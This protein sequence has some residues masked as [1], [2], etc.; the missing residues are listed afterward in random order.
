MLAFMCAGVGAK[1][2][3]GY[4]ARVSDHTGFELVVARDGRYFPDPGGFA[5]VAWSL[6]AAGLL[7]LKLEVRRAPPSA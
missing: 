3:H 7:A 5:L 2:A 4:Y 1:L 6:V